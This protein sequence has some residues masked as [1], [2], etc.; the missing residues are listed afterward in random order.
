MIVN[1]VS[2]KPK[3]SVVIA[4]QNAIGSARECL[5]A[6]EIQRAGKEIEIIAVDN[7][8]DGTTDVIAREFPG[9]K[10]VKS[11]KDKLIPELWGIGINDSAGVLIALTTAHFV[12]SENWIAEILKA[13]ES[14]YAGVGGAVENDENA[15]LVSW[16]IY[17][18]RYSRYMPPFARQE[19]VD[20]FAADN[21]SYKRAELERIQDVTRGGFWEVF[22]HGQMR[23]N[24]MRLIL[25]PNIV[26]Y[27]RKSFTFKDFIKQ[28]FLHGK[29]FG[30]AR[31]ISIPVIKRAMLILLSPLIPLVYLF[32]IS[33][34]VAARKR[35]IG[36]YLLSLP[37][38]FLFL[39]SWSAGEFSGYLRKSK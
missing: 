29:Q 22:V 14:E 17:F 38:L 33:R 27:H 34:R 32:R 30:A 7:S 9:V 31:A 11:S 28:R 3:L 25:T 21:A 26:V 4:S 10:L 23:R 12:P 35:N 16:A 5:R 36:K 13:H 8:T 2:A 37:I 15:D 6:I 1:E 39:V 19:N 20:D 18:C 24:K